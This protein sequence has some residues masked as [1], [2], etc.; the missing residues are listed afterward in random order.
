MDTKKV[1]MKSEKEFK[2]MVKNGDLKFLSSSDS[3]EVSHYGTATS[4][5]H[6]MGVW[7][8]DHDEEYLVVDHPNPISKESYERMKIMF[9]EQ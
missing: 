5:M 6:V 2:E 1:K 3:G 9:K 4:P 8:H 7:W